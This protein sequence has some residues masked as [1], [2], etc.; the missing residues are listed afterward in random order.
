MKIEQRIFQ[1]IHV[2]NC[3]KLTLTIKQFTTQGNEDSVLI[4][5]SAVP[6]LIEELKKLSK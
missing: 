5:K 6:K 3:D 4:E 2:S 1:P